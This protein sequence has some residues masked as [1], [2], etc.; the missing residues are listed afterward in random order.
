MGPIGRMGLMDFRLEIGDFR[1]DLDVFA[2]LRLGRKDFH[3]TRRSRNHQSSLNDWQISQPSDCSNLFRLRPAVCFLFG[4]FCGA[5]NSL[6]EIGY[7]CCDYFGSLRLHYVCVWPDCLGEGEGVFQRA[8]ARYGGAG[9]CV[10]F[11]VLFS[12]AAGGFVCFGR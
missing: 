4:P 1:R 5:S 3:L 7:R 2:A 12:F 8:G 6:C 11:G 10:R 9:S